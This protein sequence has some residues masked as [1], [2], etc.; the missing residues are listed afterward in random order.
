MDKAPQAE[1]FL[2]GEGD[3]WFHR[4]KDKQKIDEISPLV[5][6]HRLDPKEIVVFGCSDGW[7]VNNLHMLFPEAHCLGIDPSYDAI[8]EAR[9]KYSRP[10]VEFML[11]TAD[12]P[13]VHGA[14]LIVYGFCL[15]L[16]DRRLLPRIVMEADAMLREG[17][18]LVIHDFDPEY[19]HK[20]PYKHK[21]GLFSYKM[22]HARLW[23]VNPAYECLEKTRVT[24]EE[25]VWVLRKDTSLGWP[26]KIPT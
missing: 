10:R 14:D 23:L 21:E 18:Q 16:V 17:G 20:V 9:R 3:A 25:S 7:Q 4:N 6:R 2:R 13:R 15:Y 11:G 24:P 22:N 26:E 12:F 5:Q 19:P 8:E 1:A